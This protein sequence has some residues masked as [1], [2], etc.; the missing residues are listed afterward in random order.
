M[1]RPVEMLTE[2]VD[3][4]VLLLH[5]IMQMALPELLNAHL[6]RH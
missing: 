6:P 3:D 1:N 2:L 4:I 5:V